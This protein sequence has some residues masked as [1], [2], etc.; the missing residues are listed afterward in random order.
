M[1][2]VEVERAVADNRPTLR[3]RAI[4]A[5]LTALVLQPWFGLVFVVAWLGVLAAAEL[6]DRRVA[7]AIAAG[8]PHHQR[9]RWLLLGYIATATASWSL[10]AGL[11]WHR[12]GDALQLVA[13]LI[14]CIQMMH[15]QSYGFRSRAVLALQMGIPAATIP[16]LV[17]TGDIPDAQ[18]MVVAPAVLIGIA[19]VYAGA[20]A[21]AR[22]ARALDESRAEIERLAY[23]DVTTDLANRRRFAERLD[24]MVRRARAT[25]TGFTLVLLDLDGLKQINDRY[26]H[27]VG[28]RALMAFADRLRSA[29]G[30]GDVVARLGGDEFGWLMRAGQAPPAGGEPFCATL[31][32]A[33]HDQQLCA[34]IG[35][36]QYPADG[37]TADQLFKAA[38]VAL[39]AAK[40]NRRPCADE[41][42][43][44]WSRRPLLAG[45]AAG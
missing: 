38:D 5:L 13:I 30:A 14:L 9:H 28:D 21:N 15:A 16:W 1:L 32:I 36:A 4:V 3:L 11:L 45:G 35:V 10:I 43:Q 31:T 17:M 18:M 2:G 12:D 26:G 7:V 24:A 39:Y 19:Y 27:D 42:M 33:G 6:L 40:P 37:E 23:S 44:R 34:S 25:G 41:E 8:S 29:A 22:S 20:E